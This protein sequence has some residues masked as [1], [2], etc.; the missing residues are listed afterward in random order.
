MKLFMV[1]YFISSSFFFSLRAIFFSIHIY[2]LIGCYLLFFKLFV[3]L[4]NVFIA[5]IITSPVDKK[6]IIQVRSFIENQALKIH[7]GKT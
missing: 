5:D 4:F 7:C 3:K 1:K 6:F 2:I